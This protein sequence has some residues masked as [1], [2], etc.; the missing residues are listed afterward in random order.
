MTHIQ[1]LPFIRYL[2]GSGA[3]QVRYSAHLYRIY[4]EDGKSMVTGHTG[5]IAFCNQLIRVL[6]SKTIFLWLYKCPTI[7]AAG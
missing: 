5:K 2:S 7:S 6:N 1:K 4:S 3:V